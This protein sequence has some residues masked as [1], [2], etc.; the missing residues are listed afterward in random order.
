MA[1]HTFNAEVSKLLHLMI[2][3]LYSNKEI[4]LRELIS[5]A[6]DALDKL[7]LLTLTDEK[8]KSIDFDPKITITIDEIEKRLIISDNGIGMDDVDLVENLGTIAKS[9]T[10]QFLENL[11]SDDKKSAQL[12]GQFGVG[13]YSAFM[14]ANRVEVIS[15]KVLDDKAWIWRSDAAKEF[16]IDEVNK[17]SHGTDVILYLKKED[18]EFL[19]DFR[20]KEIVKK[21]SDH[22]PYKIF[23]KINDKVEQINRASA[24]WKLSKSEIKEEEYKEFYKTISHDNNDPLYWIHTRA[25][26]TLEYNTL[27]YIP[28]TRPLDL[29]RADYEPGV[30][31]YVKNVF[32]MEDKDLI[33][34][35]LRFIRG[36]IDSEDL[37]LNVSR[38]M[39]QH[40]VILTKI[41][42]SSVKKILTELKKL[43]NSDKE[44]YLKFWNLFGKVLK[45]GLVSDFENKETLLDLIL[46]KT[47][48]SDEYIDFQTYVGR[49][50]KDQKSI[51][52]LIGEKELKD[53]PLLD[54]F[55]KDGIEVILFNDDIDSFVI[56]SIFEYKEKKLKSI[57]STEVDEDFKNLDTLDEEKYKDLTEAIK[58][59]LKDKVKDVKVTTRLVSSPACLVFDKDDPEFQT[60]LMLKQMGNFDAKEP[61]PILEINPNHEIFTKLVL[62]NDFSLIDEIAHIIY[63]E[64]RVLEGME[65]DEPSKFAQNI[66]KI[67]S[68][69]IKSD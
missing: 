19:N 66:N 28:S 35:Y 31:L 16:E 8:Y 45:E 36:I 6:A 44:K 24:L 32:I 25:E 29:F 38:E 59:S 5:N 65:I 21:Y 17:D 18:E 43:K 27:F 46:F 69:A 10:K 61:K 12:I 54:R 15:K 60:Y 39:L 52:Y 22:I 11:N 1:K 51:Y 47:S 26:G 53:S 9:G 64:S 49:M 48:K 67:L 58:K 62:K 20:I 56:P 30:K 7:H 40:N 4:F 41:K 14:V 23:L 55:N 68:K 42:K 33:P 34:T 37:P 3:S 50:K 57:S 13:F 2:Y 63:N